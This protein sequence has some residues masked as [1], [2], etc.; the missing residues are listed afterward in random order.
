MASQEES[1]R[2]DSSSP[3]ALLY[4]LCRRLLGK[5]TDS[6]GM[7]IIMRRKQFIETCHYWLRAD[8]VVFGIKVQFNFYLL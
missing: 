8:I 6:K 5:E 1:S 3:E 4:K 2:S 7:M